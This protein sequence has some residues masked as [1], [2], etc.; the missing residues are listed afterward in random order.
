[1][2]EQS[3]DG[4]LGE[5]R[6]RG[7]SGEAPSKPALALGAVAEELTLPKQQRPIEEDGV[8]RLLRAAVGPKF[9]YEDAVKLDIDGKRYS[10]DG[11]KVENVIHTMN[12]DLKWGLKYAEIKAAA[13]SIVELNKPKPCSFVKQQLHGRILFAGGGMPL[14]VFDGYCFRATNEHL[15]KG[16]QDSTPDL[17]GED[18]ALPSYRRAGLSIVMGP[19]G[20]GKTQ[21]ARH[22]ISSKLMPPQ[23]TERG[24]NIVVVSYSTF[25]T[26]QELVKSANPAADIQRLIVEQ[27]NTHFRGA[28]TE[29]SLVATLKELNIHL[30]LDECDGCF[31]H[32]ETDFDAETAAD[33]GAN[34]G[35]KKV[36]ILPWRGRTLA[37]L[38]KVF[39]GV[40]ITIVGMMVDVDLRDVG[41]CAPWCQK[42]RMQ[43]W[44]KIRFNAYFEHRAAI[45]VLGRE[46][47]ANLTKE[48]RFERDEK[49]LNRVWEGMLLSALT[50]NARTAAY[51]VD[52]LLSVGAVTVSDAYVMETVVDGY[53]GAS[54]LRCLA[55]HERARV[56]LLALQCACGL[57][58]TGCNAPRSNIETLCIKKGLLMCNLEIVNTLKLVE[59]APWRVSLSPA[60]T[61]VS[62]RMIGLA[63]EVE[64]LNGEDS[65]ERMCALWAACMMPHNPNALPK[66]HRSTVSF[67]EVPMDE[68]ETAGNE[69][70]NVTDLPLCALSHTAVINRPMG[71]HVDI[72]A[73]RVFVR[74]AS[75]AGS[76]PLNVVDELERAGL[77]EI[78]GNPAANHFV[79]CLQREWGRESTPAAGMLGPFASLYEA[80]KDL[81]AFNAETMLTMNKRSER[82]QTPSKK[83][84]YNLALQKNADDIPEGHVRLVLVLCGNAS[85]VCVMSAGGS[86]ILLGTAH[87]QTEGCVRL[88]TATGG[89]VCVCEDAFQI[90]NDA[91][92]PLKGVVKDMKP[93]VPFVVDVLFH[94]IG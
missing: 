26:T 12:L 42:W 86:P 3:G 36:P 92:D 73:P 15:S 57:H 55:D 61:L 44:D 43:P 71:A 77:V 31:T 30:I 14:N 49:L 74:V 67:G 38:T 24:P 75:V 6:P 63:D 27:Y 39:K 11:E 32:A 21:Y 85:G 16:R 52:A 28:P 94:P 47:S 70:M 40:H 62:L 76:I 60:L 93:L 48:Q 51:L 65:V 79:K 84:Q 82:G 20:S 72:V 22:G 33:T 9:N 8:G 53:I 80:R 5:K 91:V 1:M 46:N 45:H 56:G 7:A 90:P 83:G 13:N 35:D 58:S 68:R 69:E 29:A 54:A 78:V 50:T 4:K 88:M 10:S 37:S 81:A 23:H 64:P 19:S 66:V 2:E 59:G 25:S 87:S 89:T 18:D 17:I 34:N 41:S